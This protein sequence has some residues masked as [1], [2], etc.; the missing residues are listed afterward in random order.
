MYLYFIHITVLRIYKD[1]NKPQL[2]ILQLPYTRD[3]E[4]KFGKMYD[5]FLNAT[6]QIL[7]T[8]KTHLFITEEKKR[9]RKLERDARQHKKED[10]QLKKLL[11]YISNNK[12]CYE[13]T[14]DHDMSEKDA[15]KRHK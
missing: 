8:T 11:E 2:P 14:E 10:T 12:K 1:I 13:E 3:Y 7:I 5:R 4:F 15:K 9:I 6:F